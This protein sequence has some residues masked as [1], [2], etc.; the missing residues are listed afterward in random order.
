M[1]NGLKIIASAMTKENAR[2]AMSAKSC[3]VAAEMPKPIRLRIARSTI[4]QPEA[5]KIANM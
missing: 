3:S 2:V 4:D 5:A 1:P